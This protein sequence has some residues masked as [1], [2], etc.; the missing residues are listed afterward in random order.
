[1]FST[2]CL[3][4]HDVMI[5]LPYCCLK[6]ALDAAEPLFD[7]CIITV[8][9]CGHRRCAIDS[10]IGIC[11]ANVMVVTVMVLVIDMMHWRVGLVMVRVG[12]VSVMVSVTVSVM[13]LF[14]AGTFKTF[15]C[16]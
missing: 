15:T 10:D 13:V 6:V 7:G 14:T 4:N 1:M 3:T 12:M 8:R 9:Q 16:H 2:T 11:M 5:N